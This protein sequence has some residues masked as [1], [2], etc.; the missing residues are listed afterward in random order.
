[1]STVVQK[2]VHAVHKAQPG[3]VQH[4]MIQKSMTVVCRAAHLHA[5][6]QLHTGADSRRSFKASVSVLCVTCAS[7]PIVKYRHK[8]SVVAKASAIIQ[9]IAAKH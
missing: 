4:S 2:P 1:M 3:Y 6:L 5:A 8:L 9:P 7:T